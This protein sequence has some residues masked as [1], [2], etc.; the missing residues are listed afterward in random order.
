MTT[1]EMQVNRL[2]GVALAAL[3]GGVA[4]M[5][6]GAYV[7]HRMTARR[8]P[9]PPDHPDRYGVSCEDVAFPARDGTL[10]RGWWLLSEAGAP[11]VIVAPGQAGS[12]D[13][14]VRAAARLAKAGFN[15]L[16]FDFR[17]HGRSAGERVT[18]GYGEV[19]DM[20]GALD[21]LAEKGI[22]RAG[23]LGF[24]MGGAV[25]I[26]TSVYDARI[27]AVV[28]DSPF[29]RLHTVLAAGLH[30]AGVPRRMAS[31][32]ARW[33]ILWADMALDIALEVAEPARWAP[34]VRT[35]VLVIQAGRDRFVPVEEIRWFR[36]QVTGT[37]EVWCV[38]VA[39][40]REAERVDPEAY[41]ARV[42]GW[43]NDH[44]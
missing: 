31:W 35:P 32:L 22:A 11:T 37:C 14:D 43:F 25:A 28:A 26:T 27:G 23:V 19:L 13:G 6:S 1:G 34:A 24:S 8:P 2:N 21:W 41:W 17:A 5:G 12:A 10:L 16:L 3:V 4:W 39:D 33:A 15:V 9:D 18:F 42:M 29:V 40:H 44:L 20:C 7:A 38:P 30:E 36:E